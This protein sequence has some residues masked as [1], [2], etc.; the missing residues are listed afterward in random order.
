MNKKLLVGLG[1]GLIAFYFLM[2]KG[3]GGCGC[4]DDL[5]LPSDS[6]DKRTACEKKTEAGMKNLRFI[7]AELMVKYREDAIKD[8]MSESAKSER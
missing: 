3:K 6:L 8:C 1:I 2:K 5:A 4:T 7:S